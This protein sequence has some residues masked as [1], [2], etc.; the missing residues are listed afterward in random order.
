MHHTI[1]LIKTIFQYIS[2]NKMFINNHFIFRVE[3]LIAWL[4]RLHSLKPHSVLHCLI[5][6]EWDSIAHSS[7]PQQVLTATWPG[8]LSSVRFQKCRTHLV[9]RAMNMPP[10]GGSITLTQRQ[11]S[12]S[13]VH[14]KSMLYCIWII[15]TSDPFS[16]YYKY[17]K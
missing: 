4:G 7:F 12:T 2:Q 13:F 5:P 17:K 9:R 16:K 11:S 10:N 15:Q 1:L 3:I 14:Q 8:P 6:G